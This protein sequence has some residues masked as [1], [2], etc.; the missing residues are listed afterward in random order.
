LIYQGLRPS[1]LIVYIKCFVKYDLKGSFE[2]YR[3]EIWIYCVHP[4][5]RREEKL[6][7][8]VTETQTKKCYRRDRHP[9]SQTS[10][11]SEFLLL[12]NEQF[13]RISHFNLIG[14]AL[15]AFQLEKKKSSIT[16][17]NLPMGTRQSMLVVNIQFL[18]HNM[19]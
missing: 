8:Q 14:I 11:S 9:S 6:V 15:T 12:Q 5:H 10:H 7:T 3:V 18:M 2:V 19:N 1:S 16:R 13:H 17:T 4:L